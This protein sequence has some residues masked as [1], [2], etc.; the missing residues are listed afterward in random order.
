MFKKLM[1]VCLI[2]FSSVMFVNCATLGAANAPIMGAIGT[3]ITSPAGQIVNW[4]DNNSDSNAKPISMLKVGKASCQSVLGIAAW[5]DAGIAA[6][7][8][9]GKISK[10]HHIDQKYENYLGIYQRYTILVYGE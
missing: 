1:T 8:Q 7:A 5:G 3:S 6:A 9:N 10:I 4:V 2:T